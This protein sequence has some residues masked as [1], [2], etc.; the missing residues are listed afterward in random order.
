MNGDA[1]IKEVTEKSSEGAEKPK[2]GRE[3]GNGRRERDKCE[4]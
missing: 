2:C 1:G 3:G 4:A